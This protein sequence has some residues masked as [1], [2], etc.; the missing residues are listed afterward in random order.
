M[1]EALGDGTGPEIFYAGN[2]LSPHYHSHFIKKLSGKRFSINAISKSGTTTE[3]ALAF[4]LIRSLLEKEMG[5]AEAKE[6]IVATTDEKKGALRHFATEEGYET[7]R[8]AD[9]VGGR[10]SVLSPVGLLP[11]AVVGIDID[12]LR[13]GAID[14]AS[15]CKTADVNTNPAAFY[16]AARNILYRKGYSN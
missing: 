10:Y 12:Q 14:A 16:A 8:I 6:R 13:Q 2:S 4:R 7:L 1:I 11:I 5:K 3:P 9:D 15:A